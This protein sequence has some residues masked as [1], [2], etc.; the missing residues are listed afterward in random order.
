MIT[1]LTTFHKEGLEQY[2]QRFLDSFALKVDKR[3]KMLC[4]AEQCVPNNPDNQQIVIIDQQEVKPLIDF[5]TLKNNSDSS[6]TLTSNNC[7]H[8]YPVGDNKYNE[9]LLFGNCAVPNSFFK[10]LNSFFSVLL[11]AMTSMK[12]ELVL[13]SFKGLLYLNLCSFLAFNF[14]K[15]FL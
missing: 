1:V 10:L 6:S 4:Y 9:L 15:I 11:V 2:G 14:I 3:I 7:L 8:L 5:T 13:L 12:S